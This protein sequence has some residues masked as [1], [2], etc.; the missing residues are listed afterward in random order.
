M[1]TKQPPHPQGLE[2]KRSEAPLSPED[3]RR[4]DSFL[5][6][7]FE[8][9]DYDFNRALSGRYGPDLRCVFFTAEKHNSLIG[10]AG[11]LL[12]RENPSAAIVAPVAV[13]PQCRGRGVGTNLLASVLDYL[14]SKR[15][16]AAYLGVR[17]NN[18]A[19]NLYERAGFETYAGLIMRKLLAPQEQFEKCFAV[20]PV[21]IR[22]LSWSD[23][24]AVM[25]LAATPAQMYTLDL[26]AQFFSTKYIEPARFLSV[27]PKMM[28]T[29]EQPSAFANV[30][31][32]EQSH[33]V[34]GIAQIRN[35]VDSGN[36]AELEFF[37]HD[38][39]LELASSFLEDTLRQVKVVATCRC[40][41]CD[42]TKRAIIESVG[43]K[44]AS[45]PPQSVFLGESPMDVILY[46]LEARR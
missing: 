2:M 17:Q 46:R 39:F 22:Q 16:L 30:L 32:S 9:G 29:L 45:I 23:W 38:N 15:C 25:A 12:G 14:K 10:A 8:Y 20:S 11:C 40:A 5:L 31:I 36:D 34:V 1:K 3:V 13:T 21:T 42:V 4:I 27:F 6:N 26:H 18:P 24:P 19:V 44:V 7:I 33:A 41:A 35:T 43:G 37:I 28:R